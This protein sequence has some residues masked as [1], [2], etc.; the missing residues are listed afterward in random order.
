MLRDSVKHKKYFYACAAYVAMQII[1]L[2]TR[3]VFSVVDFGA[4]PQE[5]SDA[6][7]SAVTQIAAMAGIPLLICIL[8]EKEKPLAFARDVGFRSTLRWWVYPVSFVI[9]IMM[10]VFSTGASYLTQVILL[11]LGGRFIPVVSEPTNSVGMFVLALFCTAVLPAICEE[12]LH[13]GILVRGLRAH[14]KDTWLVV[15]TAFLFALMHTNITQTLYTFGGGLLMGYFAVKAR[16]I[17]PA[18]IMHFTNNAISTYVEY[19]TEFD[20]FGG[21]SLNAMYDYVGENMAVATFVWIAGTAAAVALTWVCVR[22]GT[23]R[24]AIEDLE[25]E[26]GYYYPDY[27]TPEG[28]SVEISSLPAGNR[29][30]YGRVKPVTRLV[31]VERTWIDV[32]YA[33]GILYTA[34]TLMWRLL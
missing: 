30:L 1:C 16:S 26:D 11:S 34:F 2:V 4:M 29:P 13:R 10:V 23:K 7:W 33:I 19:A 14:Y 3:I 8:G 27:A 31:G 28:I 18:V 20:W 5:S 15:V 24:D 32:C 25:T 9:G 17:W 21:S 6:I 22:Y 12:T